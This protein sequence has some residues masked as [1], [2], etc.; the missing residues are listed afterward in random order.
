VHKNLLRRAG[1]FLPSVQKHPFLAAARRATVAE[2]GGQEEEGE[3][4]GTGEVAAG[5]GLVGVTKAAE[6]VTVAD[7]E[8]AVHKEGETTTPGLESG[9]PYRH[10][11]PP[12]SG[13]YL[14]VLVHGFQGNVT[15][16]FSTTYTHYPPSLVAHTS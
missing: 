4:A 16:S 8:E 3:G 7:V 10:S 12:Y 15:P 1:A 13:Q 14:V 9:S 2:T 5:G 11:P 6:A